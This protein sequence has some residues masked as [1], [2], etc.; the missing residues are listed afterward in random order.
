MIV[1][2]EQIDSGLIARIRECLEKGLSVQGIRQVSGGI[3]L[4]IIMFENESGS[5]GQN[6]SERT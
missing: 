2:G 6:E 5:I 4:P 1:P 3:Y